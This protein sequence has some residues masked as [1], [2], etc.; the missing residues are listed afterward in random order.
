MIFIGREQ[1]CLLIGVDH[2]TQDVVHALVLPD[3]DPDGFIQLV[4]EAR[5]DA[6]YPLR[7]VVSD[8]A[9]SRLTRITSETF[10]FRHPA[11]TSTA[12]WTTTSRR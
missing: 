4:T 9:I 6:G 1:H 3:E 10:P 8:L 2:L 12:A 7:G 11:C 5:L